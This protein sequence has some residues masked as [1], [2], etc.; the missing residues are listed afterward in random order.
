MTTTTTN[1]TTSA[2]TEEKK[3]EK[4]DNGLKYGTGGTTYTC[5]HSGITHSWG[6][7]DEYQDF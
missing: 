7:G 5:P 4:K 1:A 3:E 6:Y 2:A